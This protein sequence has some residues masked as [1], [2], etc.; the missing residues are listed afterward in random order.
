MPGRG[1]HSSRVPGRTGARWS[2]A[3]AR[4]NRHLALAFWLITFVPAAGALA[5]HGY[6]RTNWLHW[7]HLVFFAAVALG[8]AAA[9]AGGQAKAAARR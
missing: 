6:S 8:L 9:W 4:R 1:S 5:A 3:L 7:A 2:S